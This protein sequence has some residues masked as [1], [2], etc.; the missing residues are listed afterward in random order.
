VRP[1]SHAH[2]PLPIVPFPPFFTDFPFLQRLVTEFVR[3]PESS[4]SANFHRKINGFRAAAE[5]KIVKLIFI[6]AAGT[7]APTDYIG[8]WMMMANE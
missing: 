3:S 1:L 2:H 6:C 7:H 8:R 4:S 5:L